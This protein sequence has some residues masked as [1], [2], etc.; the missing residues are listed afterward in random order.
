MEDASRVLSGRGS[1][2]REVVSGRSCFREGLWPGGVL[3]ELIE[4]TRKGPPVRAFKVK[5][6][7]MSF[8][9]E[10]F[11]PGGVLSERG[12]SGRGLS[13]LDFVREV[14]LR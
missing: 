10:G 6:S 4:K 14:F 2:P 3:S 9:R 8:V 13:G 1:C 12:L 5:H 7:I 11:C